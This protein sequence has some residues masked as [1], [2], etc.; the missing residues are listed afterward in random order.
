VSQASLVLLLAEAAEAAEAKAAVAVRLVTKI[1]SPLRRGK[2]LQSMSVLVAWVVS[3]IQ[4]VA[5]VRLAPFTV[6]AHYWSGQ[7]AVRASVVEQDFPRLMEAVMAGSVPMRFM[8]R[9][10]QAQEGTQGLA[11]MARLAVVTAQQVL[12]AAAAVHRGVEFNMHHV[13]RALH[14][15]MAAVA[16]AVSVLTAKVLAVQLL[17]LTILVL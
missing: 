6:P 11:G 10:A 14:I 12:A 17:P 15:G 1:A 2:L 7:T 13:F 16:A 8:L 3:I 4:S 5:R 9:A